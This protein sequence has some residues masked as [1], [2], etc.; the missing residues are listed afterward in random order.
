MIPRVVAGFLDFRQLLLHRVTPS[1]QLL[2][3]LLVRILHTGKRLL[4]LNIQ[5]RNLSIPSVKLLFEL[6]DV[7]VLSWSQF[8]GQV[9]SEVK[10][11]SCC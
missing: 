11:Y 1:A 6:S 9:G 10:V 8:V 3:L 5:L 4:R 2:E 7:G